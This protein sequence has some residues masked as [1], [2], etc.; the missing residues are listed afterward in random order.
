[1]SGI[2]SVSL[3]KRLLILLSELSVNSMR[4]GGQAGHHP[5]GLSGQP[6]WAQDWLS[7]LPTQQLPLLPCSRYATGRVA[8]S[9]VNDFFLAVLFRPTPTVNRNIH[10]KGKSML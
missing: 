9:H 2:S 3:L 5:W 4:K 1:M 10:W 7:L 6:V 8:L